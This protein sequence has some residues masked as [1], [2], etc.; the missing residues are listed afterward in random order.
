[1]GGIGKTSF[2]KE[3]CYRY[4]KEF[5]GKVFHA[6][7]G[8]GKSK[9]ELQEDVVRQFTNIHDDSL[10]LAKDTK[11]RHEFQPLLSVIVVCVCR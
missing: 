6:E 2:C 5:E 7:L 10:K 4:Y 3:L 11:V 1:M 8:T 9:R